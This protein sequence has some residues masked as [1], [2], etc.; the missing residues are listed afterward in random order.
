[1]RSKLCISPHKPTI[2]DNQKHNMNRRIQPHGN[3][4]RR[5][6]ANVQME[7]QKGFPPAMTYPANQLLEQATKAQQEFGRALK[8]FQAKIM[9][10]QQKVQNL[11]QRAK[12]QHSEM[13]RLKAVYE[14]AVFSKDAETMAKAL[15]A[16]EQLRSQ[17]ISDNKTLQAT[18]A[19]LPW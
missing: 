13:M 6:P 3:V 11:A 2:V 17:I 10:D 7:A 12:A 18:L 8:T 16:A 15:K 1:M 5:I 4:I 19:N 9:A 14:D